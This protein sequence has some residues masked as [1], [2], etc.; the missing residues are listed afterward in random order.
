MAVPALSEALV[1]LA[2]LPLPREPETAYMAF[3][4]GRDGVIDMEFIANCSIG[5]WAKRPP[6][7]P[8]HL[9]LSDR[10]RDIEVLAGWVLGIQVRDEPQICEHWKADLSKS[11]RVARAKL[12]DELR[13]L[14]SGF[15]ALTKLDYTPGA[16]MHTMVQLWMRLDARKIQLLH[17]ILQSLPGSCAPLFVPL[18]NWKSRERHDAAYMQHYAFVPSSFRVYTLGSTAKEECQGADFE[19][20][21]TWDAAL[22]RARAHCQ[23]HHKHEGESLDDLRPQLGTVYQSESHAAAA[24]RLSGVSVECDNAG[25]SF[26]SDS[27]RKNAAT[28]PP[29]PTAPAAHST[30]HAP[31]VHQRAAPAL[32][33]RT[34]DKPQAGRPRTRASAVAA[35]SSSSTSIS[36]ASSLTTA[37]LSAPSLPPSSHGAH[38]GSE[39][40][41]T[42]LPTASS[43]KGSGF[44]INESTGVV[45][46]SA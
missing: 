16:P 36:T 31:V 7:T 4:D 30:G 23:A 37:S 11:P 29:A 18:Q 17:C 13:V 22:E 35:T 42:S 12:R 14:L 44:F 39:S 45:Y 1:H 28:K 24:A 9:D 6:F 27:D 41:S 43:L 25:Y 33:P 32:R 21:H 40:A 26:C 46:T 3:A 5:V 2:S 20:F 34:G 15:E 38:P 10:Q 8:P 19:R